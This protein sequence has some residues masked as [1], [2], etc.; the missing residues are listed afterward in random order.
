MQIKTHSFSSTQNRMSG[1][2]T[3]LIRQS[4]EV[5]DVHHPNESAGE[6]ECN[7]KSQLLDPGMS[8][9]EVDRKKMRSLP[10]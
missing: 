2:N 7:F 9:S 8:W 10:P 6:G 1:E 3:T 4:V 5:C